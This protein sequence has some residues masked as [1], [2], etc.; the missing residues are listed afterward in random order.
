MSLTFKHLC[1]LLLLSS[2][3]AAA[4]AK[5][6]LIINTGDELFEVGEFPASVL[7]DNPTARF[8]K[9]G[10]KCAHLGVFWSDIWRWD[11]GLVEMSGTDA[12]RDIPVKYLAQIKSDP[13]YGLSKAKRG[14]WKKYGFWTVLILLGGLVG[15]RFL[16]RD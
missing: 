15:F 6:P 14:I 11:C 7:Q 12:Y 16:T 8:G 2:A 4:S 3:A 1:A 13:S 10:Y 5:G 9:V